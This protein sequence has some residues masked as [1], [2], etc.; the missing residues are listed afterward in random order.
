MS[1]EKSGSLVKDGLTYTGGIA[2]AG[3]AAYGLYKLG[4]AIFGKNEEKNTSVDKA[5]QAAEIA[6]AH[7]EVKEAVDASA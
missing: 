1:E 6:K 7:A 4:T 3:A 2:V 5:K